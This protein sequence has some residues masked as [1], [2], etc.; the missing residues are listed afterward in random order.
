[1]KTFLAVDIGASSGRHMLGWMEDGQIRMQEIYRFENGMISRDGRLCWDV[2]R[3]FREILEG[4]KKCR[5]L[6]HIP[7][8]MGI[9]TWAVDYVLLDRDGRLLGPAVGYR[10]S[11]TRGVD[12][13]V[14]ALVPEE[15]LY[16]RTGIQKQIF[17]TIY[18][19]MAVKEQ[20]PELLERAGVMLMIPDYFHFLLTGKKG[21]EYTNATTTQLV[22][23]RTGDW[24]RE[25]IGKLGFPLEI[26][27][28]I[29]DPGKVLGE[30]TEEIQKEVGF[31][32]RVVLPAT[33][34]TG[35]AVLAMPCQEE[36]GL[37]ISSGTWSLMGT[38]VKKAVCTSQARM[39]NL[40]N[41]GGYERRFRLLKNIMGLWM[42]QSVRHED[43][44]TYSFGQICRWAEENREFP[45]RVD[46]NDESFLAPASMKAAVK[47][48][49]QKTGQKIPRT[50]GEV[51]AVIYQS[52]AE[53]YGRTAK[54]IEA[55]TG[56]HYNSIY[57]IGGGANADYLSRLTADAA[58][59]RVMAG[60]TEATAAGNLAVQMKTAGLFESLKEARTCIRQS[61][62]VKTFE[63]DTGVSAQ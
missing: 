58:G 63:P 6:G 20:E 60:P 28:E 11:R 30:L 39:A 62:P 10:D 25:L 27:Q 57:I 40:T 52:L 48:Y 53:C 4:M 54:E 26:F 23:A 43:Q 59:R 3:L 12:E 34:D 19:L 44:D 24:D 50:T 41:E 14:Y 51:G 5:S 55:V 47:E 18:Q 49:C 21:T 37:Y 13:K 31:N 56:E 15:E 45:S 46:V 22:N 42:I 36:T 9:D 2:D 7:E 32:C 17:N 33:H 1:M 38:E 29:L 8:S 61:F 35:S 16:D